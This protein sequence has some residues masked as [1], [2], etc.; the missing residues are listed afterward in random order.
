MEH[1]GILVDVV[2]VVDTVDKGGH[3]GRIPPLSL[4]KCRTAGAAV[5]H[6]DCFVRRG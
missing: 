3:G 4:L 1:S 2:D 5:S 6:P